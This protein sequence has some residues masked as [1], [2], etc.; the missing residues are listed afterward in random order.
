MTASPGGVGPRAIR[1][2]LLQGFMT[3]LSN[4]LTVA[5]YNNVVPGASGMSMLTFENEG[6]MA[7]FDATING[8]DPVL[9]HVHFGQP[10]SNGPIF[11]DFSSVKV[12]MGRFLGCISILDLGHTQQSVCELLAD[13]YLYYFEF[14]Q[15]D[16]EPG[17]FTTIRGQLPRLNK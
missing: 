9:A 15:S 14:H 2:Q 12:E 13:G 16:T 10:G 8:F 11:F 5:P 4:D 1:G 17:I 7:C 6:T 3:K